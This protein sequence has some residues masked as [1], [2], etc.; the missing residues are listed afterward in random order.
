LSYVAACRFTEAS[1]TVTALS[2]LSQQP[3]RIKTVPFFVMP[4]FPLGDMVSR[5]AKTMLS[6]G[7]F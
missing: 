2:R 4:A 3:G 5:E 7:A 1:T 6:A